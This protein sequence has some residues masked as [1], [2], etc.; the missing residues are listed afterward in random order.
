MYREVLVA[1]QPLFFFA[2]AHMALDECR[3]SMW[4]KSKDNGD[5]DH[6]LYEHDVLHIGIVAACDRIDYYHIYRGFYTHKSY[7]D[8]L[9]RWVSKM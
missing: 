2:M 9:R 3:G 8:F 4:M 7:L 5:L 6:I 1:P